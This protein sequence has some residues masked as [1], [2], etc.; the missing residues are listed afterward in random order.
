MQELDEM[1]IFLLREEKAKRGRELAQNRRERENK[2][3]M[4]HEYDSS[5]ISWIQRCE[6]GEEAVG[7]IIITIIDCKID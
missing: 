7:T 1:I 6:S 4:W 3:A 5:K 2:K